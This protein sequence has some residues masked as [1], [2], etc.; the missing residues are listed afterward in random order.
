MNLR[1]LAKSN[2]RQ[3]SLRLETAQGAFKKGEYAYAIRQ[4]Q[5]CV[6]LALKGALNFIGVEYPHYHEV[7]PILIEK[8]SSFSPWF[9]NEIEEFANISK[10]LARKREPAMYGQEVK[11]LTPESLFTKKE[12]NEVLNK[13]ENLFK[14]TKKLVTG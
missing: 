1:D 11:G 14:K 3:A 12:A 13:T 10:D 6:E 5:E 2:I 7:S 9:R 8:K 4:C